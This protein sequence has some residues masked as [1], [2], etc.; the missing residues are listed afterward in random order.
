MEA[1]VTRLKINATNLRN[2]L[3]SYNKQLSK[4]RA[5]ENRLTFNAQRRQVQKQKE[6]SVEK[7][8]GGIGGAIENIKS[9]IVSGPLGFF[10]K[11]K[12][13]LGIVLLGVLINNLPKLIDKLKKFF[14]DNQWLIKV[15]K[16]TLDIIS[17]GIMGMIW[18]VDEYPA[19][20][21]KSIDNERRWVAKEIDR[22]IAL[23]QGAYAIWDKFLNPKQDPVPN[24][25]LGVPVSPGSMYPATTPSPTPSAPSSSSPTPSTQR[26]QK[27]Q[28][29]QGLAKGGTVK[30]KGQASSRSTITAG[31]RGATPTPI[32]RRAIESIDSFQNFEIVASETKLN[33]QLLADKEGVND[34]FSK[35]NQ[36]FSKFLEF[37]ER[38]KKKTTP[39]GEDPLDTMDPKASRSGQ[40]NPMI[41]FNAVAVDKEDIIG[42][43]GSTGEST[44]PHLHV[45]WGNGYGDR[46][47]RALS[48]SILNGVFIGGKSLA[49]LRAEGG[50]GDGLGANRGHRGFDFPHNQGAPITLGPGVRFAS[51]EPGY[52]AGYG[53]VA[54]VVDSSGQQYLLGHLSG[55]PTTEAL[56]KIKEKRMS[57]KEQSTL[58]TIKTGSVAQQNDQTVISVNQTFIQPQLVPMPMPF[59]V[60]NYGLNN[61]SIT[62]NTN[63]AFSNI[64]W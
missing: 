58:N 34:T 46:G 16:A 37:F 59:T 4:I 28:K 1:Q 10:D 14:A 6:E 21:M 48:Q 53:H 5:E 60:P 26:S 24:K 22:T 13:F 55:G 52:N 35:V 56:R 39:G 12:E 38:D 3:V 42:R 15:I 23:A 47:N 43:I 19:G 8:T 7:G 32:G 40:P 25:G 36:S 9:R 17:K 54:I 29:P 33:A 44:G 30:N 51:Y 49:Q 18:L 11:V 63:N 31:F 50:Q 20:V 64:R 41:E 62:P 61:P 45:E 57:K 2:S 27:P